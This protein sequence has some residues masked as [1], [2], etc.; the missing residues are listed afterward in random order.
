MNINNKNINSLNSTKERKPEN[1][2]RNYYKHK[3]KKNLKFPLT[4]TRL[5]HC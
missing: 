5:H 1:I 4:Q 2:R 3:K